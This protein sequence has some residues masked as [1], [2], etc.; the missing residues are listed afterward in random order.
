MISDTCKRAQEIETGDYQQV[1]TGGHCTARRR[2][3]AKRK[4]A[5]KKPGE[6]V[7]AS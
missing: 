6:T 5:K 2:S 1:S 7:H 3:G 4:R